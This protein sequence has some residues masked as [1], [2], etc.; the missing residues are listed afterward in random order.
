MSAPPNS[1]RPTVLVF[2]GL[3]PGGGAGL[4]ADVLTIAALGAHALP[5]ATAL[6]VQDNDHVFAVT[7]VD[8]DLLERQAMTLL[9]KMQVHA[10]KIGMVGSSANGEAIARVIGVLRARHP[11]LPVVLDPVCV[12]GQGDTLSP[13]AALAPL[14]PLASLITPNLPEAALLADCAGM[15]GQVQ[16][17]GEQLRRRWPADVLITGG[18]A[19]D[20]DR[21]LVVNHWFGPD[22]ARAWRWP[23]LAGDFHGSGCTLAAAIAARLACGDAMASALDTAQRATHE[24]LADSFSI[25]SGQRIP[26]RVRLADHLCHVEQIR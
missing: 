4:A 8:A 18:H 3:D 26:A 17:Q 11:A 25:A 19:S 12:S 22:G 1:S 13:L 10:V 15:Q 16:V 24:A 21:A 14:L 23:R 9:A 5:L 6:T 2:A 7:A 20:A